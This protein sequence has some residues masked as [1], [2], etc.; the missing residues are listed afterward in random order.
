M[1]RFVFACLIASTA[2]PALASDWRPVRQPRVYVE[3]AAPAPFY[4]LPE[5]RWAPPY[6]PRWCNQD[7][8]PCDPP[9]Y[10]QA[11]GRCRESR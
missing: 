9:S 7:Y 3:T 6:C 10:K 5:N 4:T 11:D 8:S 2:L 1:V